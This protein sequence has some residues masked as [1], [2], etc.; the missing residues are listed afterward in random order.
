MYFTRTWRDHQKSDSGPAPKKPVIVIIN[1]RDRSPSVW[2]KEV[3]RPWQQHTK[4]TSSWNSGKT[5]QKEASQ[6]LFY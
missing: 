3:A 2:L 1:L 6:V 4:R 5:S